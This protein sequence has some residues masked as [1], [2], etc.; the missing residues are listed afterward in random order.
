MKALGLLLIMVL[1]APAGVLVLDDFEGSRP[2]S[3]WEGDLTVVQKHASHGAGSAEIRF[4]T[5]EIAAT[6]FPG[7]WRGYQRLLF[8]IYSNHASIVTPTLRIYDEVSL[9]GKKRDYYVA[10]EKLFVQKGWN[11]IEIRLP[12]NTQSLER[13]LDLSRIRRLVLADGGAGTMYLDNLRLASGEEPSTSAS[14]TRPEDT[15][16]SI[17]GRFFSVR[18]VARP[19]DVPEAADVTAL[20]KEAE[21][22][23]D[24][25]RKTIEAAHVQG[26]ETIYQERHLVTAELGLRVRPR[27]AWFNNDESKREMYGYVARSCRE[28]R[29]ELEDLISGM[30]RLP[31]VDDTQIA[32]PLVPPLP[33]L[34]GSPI[35]NWFFTDK[36]GD[37]MMI[38]SLHSPSLFLQRFFASPLQHIESYSVGGGSRWTIDESPVYQAF[39]HDSDTHRVGWDGWCGHLIRDLDSM[40]GTKLEN[41]VIC[42]ES[43][44]IRAAIE[45]YI[46]I[47][48]PKF[49]NNPDLLYNILAY[50]LS[51]ICYCDRSQHMFREWLKKKHGSI[52]AANEKWR[53]SYRSFDEVVAPPVKDQRPLPGVNRGLWYD[54]TRFNQDRFTDHLIWVRDLVRKIDPSIPL[55]AG[56]SSYM[57]S[58]S[59]G[60]SGI[61]EERIVNEVDD[62][63]I[64]EGGGSTMGLDL[65]LAFSNKPKPLADPEMNLGSVEYL[66]PHVLHGK[67]VAQLWHWPAQ[68]GQEF[69]SN[70]R[71]SLAHGWQYTLRDIGEVLRAGLD[72]RRLNKE[73]AAFVATQPEVAILYSQT[74]TLQLPPEMLTWGVT[75]YLAELRKTYDAALRLES[76]I[77]FVT[78]RQIRAGRLER[79]K[80]LIVPAARNVPEDVVAKIWEYASGGGHVLIT[81]ESLVG[82]EYNRPQP[83][84]S[85]LGIE[86]VRTQ[87][88]EVTAGR[89][90][91]RGYDQSFSREVSFAKNAAIALRP[92]AGGGELTAIGIRQTLAAG[93]NAERLYDYP[94]GGA[95]VVRSPLGKGMVYYSAA[96][97]ERAAYSRLLDSIFDQAE[98]HR[99]VRIVPEDGTATVDIEA[100]FVETAGRRLLYIVNFGSEPAHLRIIAP[101]GYTNRLNELRKGASSAGD[102]ILVEA[103]D[104]NIYEMF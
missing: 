85:R 60:T 103:G 70:N 82:D 51:Y 91:V 45:E 41:T 88:P 53:A 56:G 23:E 83:Y 57:L 74:S 38:L 12:L 11:H 30:R 78:E 100:R 40:G 19:G 58:G 7:D 52:E 34:K 66:M 95:A 43:P 101:A 76:K 17:D 24:L 39:L 86:I 68:P 64:H 55:A 67:S 96:S 14:R 54:W 77:T 63:I 13:K 10:D 18:Q 20:E 71:T 94:D 93:P 31:D 87:Q 79:Y 50:E 15:V 73:I 102:R 36:H 3:R 21:R 89:G 4:G 42:L 84:L 62:L 28:G 25:L 46:R 16:T 47:N 104:T 61:D 37:P 26:I 72:M 48:I 2:A 29:L 59:A 5:G 98:V 33:A 8:D 65:Q 27:L 22:E 49:N 90:F 69:H 92:V 32:R 1:A 81:P 99:P 35:R 44:A 97:L 80:L 75:P 9:G 6:R